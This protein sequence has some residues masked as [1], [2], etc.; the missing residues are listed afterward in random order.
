MV[1]RVFVG[2]G[3]RELGELSSGSAADLRLRVLRRRDVDE[4]GGGCTPIL[5]RVLACRIDVK[6][7]R[8]AIGKD[9][10][11]CCEDGNQSSELG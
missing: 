2:G 5:I 8:A 9:D 6:M 4:A 3:L 10:W 11:C 1:L 7:E